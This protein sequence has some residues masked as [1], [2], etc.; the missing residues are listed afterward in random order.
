VLTLAVRDRRGQF[1]TDIQ[2]NQ[3]VIKGQAASVQRLELDNA[4]RQILLLLDSSGSMG[5]Y[6]S[7]SW[8]NVTQ[9]AI[10]FTLQRKGDDLPVLEY[11]FA[12]YEFRQS[13][14]LARPPT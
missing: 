14:V 11:A 8:S 7:L 6:K 3:I 4:P 13:W 10:Q 12:W 2:A 9:F 5:N 1:V